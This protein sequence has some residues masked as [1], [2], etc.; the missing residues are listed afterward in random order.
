MTDLL[1]KLLRHAEYSFTDIGFD[2]GKLTVRE[3]DIL[4]REDMAEIKA[5]IDKLNAPAP[6]HVELNMEED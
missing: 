1:T 3:K 5:R 4:T 2:W 6:P